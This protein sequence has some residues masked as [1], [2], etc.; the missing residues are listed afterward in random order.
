[1]L[2]ADGQ[3]LASQEAILPLNMLAPGQVLPASVFFPGQMALA[4]V[5]AQVITAMRLA[6]GDS[7]Y[8]QTVI[9]NLLVSVAWNGLSANVQGQIVLPES[10]KPA[11][12][13]WLAA[14][15]Y[16]ANDQAVGYR[17]W[18]WSGSLKPGGSQGFALAVYSLGPAIQRVEVL[19]EARP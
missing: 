14:V 15:A 1:M 9:Q 19:V 3:P 8:L 10:E 11:A 17:R 6:P 13:L 5:R 12:R 16:A 18:E 2:G 4:P 7:R